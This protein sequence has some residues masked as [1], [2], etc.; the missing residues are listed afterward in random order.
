MSLAA[1]NTF[2][3][4]GLTSAYVG[5]SILGLTLI[6]II[7]VQPF[8]ERAKFVGTLTVF[9]IAI[10][11]RTAFILGQQDDSLEWRDEA[12]YYLTWV[13]VVAM[14]AWVLGLIV[15][16]I[17]T[18]IHRRCVGYTCSLVCCSGWGRALT[19]RVSG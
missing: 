12:I 3:V 18:C 9:A 19:R 8:Q 7:A 13:I 2:I 16:I 6:L 15:T 1:A 11:Y 17:G 14:F 10:I 4:D 5:L